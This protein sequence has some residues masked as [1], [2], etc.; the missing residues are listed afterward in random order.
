MHMIS[1]KHVAVSSESPDGTMLFP[2][3]SDMG[4]NH[5]GSDMSPIKRPVPS[6]RF[7]HCCPCFL[8]SSQMAIVGMLH[9]LLFACGPIGFLLCA[10]VN[11]GDRNN[12]GNV[13]FMLQVLT[14][15]W[16]K[17]QMVSSSFLTVRPS[18]LSST[19]SCLSH[20]IIE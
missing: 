2:F 19:F 11:L 17:T 1:Y 4:F 6:L 9:F 5:A 8:L 12:K 15:L 20:A 13:L 18:L 3:A 14:V 10:L 16:P 7:V